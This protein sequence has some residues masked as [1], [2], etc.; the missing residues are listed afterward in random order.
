MIAIGWQSGTSSAVRLAP[1]IAA[2]RATPITSPFL[3]L[4]DSISIS[5]SGR[6]R[7]APPARATRWVSAL[8]ETSTMCA[9][10]SA[11]KWVSSL[12]G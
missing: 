3:A 6:I 9:W 2:I 10:P 7:I 8:A 12:I 4:P 5:V 11:S 1:W